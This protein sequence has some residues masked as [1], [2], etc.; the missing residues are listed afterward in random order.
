MAGD[1]EELEALRRLAELEAK[2]GGTAPTGGGM[3]P[4]IANAAWGAATAIPDTL[5]NA[6]TNLLNLGRAAVGTAAMA[7]GRG[8]YA[9][10]ISPTP[11]F[12]RRGAEA[13]GLINPNVRP[14]GAVQKTVDLATRGVVGGALTGGA[15]IPGAITGAGMGATSALAGGAAQELTGRP[16]AAIIAGLAAP[17]AVAKT[18]GGIRASPDVEL[19][20]KAGVKM[21]P[22]Q[23]AGGTLQRIEDALTSI[24]YVGDIVKSAQ[25][26]GHE[27]YG[28][29]VGN[30]ALAPIKE[31][32]PTGLKGNEAVAYV[33]DKLGARYDAL[34]NQMKGSL[35]GPSQGSQL[36]LPPPNPTPTLRQE[37]D[38]IK[39]AGQNL[40][41]PQREQL[42]RIIQNEVVDRFTPQGLAGGETIKNIESKLGGMAKD[43]GRSDNYDVRNLAGAVKETQAALR[44]MVERENP[45]HAQELAKLNEGYSVFKRMQRA[46]S[47]VAAKDGVFTPAQF[48]SAVKAADF[49]KDK[50]RFARGEALMQ[51]VSQAGKNVLSPS[52]PDS[53]T[54][55]RGIVGAG[56]LGGIPYLVSHPGIAAGGLAATLPYTPAGQSLAQWL[57]MNQRP[58]LGA[59]AGQSAPLV[60]SGML[61]DQNR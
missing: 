21:T 13:I 56:A 49:S 50:S 51:D 26:R 20:H 16:E 30:A 58:E 5:L 11:D 24:P 37:L 43:M 1:R 18:L 34:R 32:V 44:R 57:M 52:V 28:V 10:E 35:D 47:S 39:T 23:M 15:S 61:S 40:P 54:A 33:Q 27:S 12:A 48:H 60:L 14:S 17:A 4:V 7:M 9:P 19:L 3:V 42:T 55:L 38:A 46:A 53:G 29:S 2:S 25:R 22:G 6:P 45:Q 8:E 31:K 36:A 59:I 41:P